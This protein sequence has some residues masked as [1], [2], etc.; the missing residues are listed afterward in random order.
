MKHFNLTEAD[1]QDIAE[2][3]VNKIHPSELI[4]AREAA[5]ILGIS[6]SR[7]YQIKDRLGYIKTG[8]HKQSP[9]RFERRQVD[10]FIHSSTERGISD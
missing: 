2:R 7:V 6:I 10:K 8:E 1:R 4:T 3:I 5:K 9:I